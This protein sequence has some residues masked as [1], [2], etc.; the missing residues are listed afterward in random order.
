MPANE[1]SAP[2]PAAKMAPVTPKPRKLR[3][4]T[5][6]NAASFRHRKTP[7]FTRPAV[8]LSSRG[9]SPAAQPYVRPQPEFDFTPTAPAP[10]DDED[11]D[12][13]HLPTFR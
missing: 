5:S 12:V 1:S 9:A 2:T 4:A 10:E 6:R 7:S 3:H 11:E 13:N 8:L